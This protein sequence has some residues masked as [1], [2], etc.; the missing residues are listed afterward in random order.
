MGQ[1]EIED[2]IARKRWYDGHDRI[3]PAVFQ[4]DLRMQC[5]LW[6]VLTLWAGDI[7]RSFSTSLAISSLCFFGSLRSRVV[8]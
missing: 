2:N 4:V 7:C 1:V 6:C 8:I 3:C 5:V